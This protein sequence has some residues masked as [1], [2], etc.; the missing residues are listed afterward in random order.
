MDHID[1]AIEG[2]SSENDGKRR[3]F[4]ELGDGMEE[5]GMQ[6]PFLGED[7]DDH[8]NLII[9]QLKVLFLENPEIKESHT[10]K[11]DVRFA[12]MSTAELKVLL[13]N[14]KL[15]LR[16]IHPHENSSSI[17]GAFGKVLEKY[18]GYTGIAET[19]LKDKELLLSI[20]TLIPGFF[21]HLTIPMKIA[22]RISH[23]LTNYQCGTP[24]PIME[25]KNDELL[26]SRNG[27]TK[28]GTKKKRSRSTYEAPNE[29]I[30]PGESR[31]GKNDL[32]SQVN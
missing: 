3:R 18:W 16:L 31:D 23:H 21:E 5:E 13:E 25:Q 28:Q 6:Y 9:K 1:E 30:S 4:Q 22:Y 14:I 29:T 20:E 15:E 19:L 2:I 8:R 12:R 27:P 24:F 32:N 26:E 11:L 7:N 10:S 17:V